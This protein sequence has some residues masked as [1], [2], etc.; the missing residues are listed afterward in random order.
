MTE[1]FLSKST[2]PKRSLNI[3]IIHKLEY[4]FLHVFYRN[5][6]KKP[7][8]KL[9]AL[10]LCT[11]SCWSLYREMPLASKIL[12]NAENGGSS[13][14]STTT[15]LVI[16]QCMWKK[17]QDSTIKHITKKPLW[18]PLTLKREVLIPSIYAIMTFYK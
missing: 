10:S 8:K 13:M 2:P 14:D 11:L 12:N 3:G 15:G 7:P 18:K 6:V 16:Q 5:C 1:N 17:N 9:F 4:I